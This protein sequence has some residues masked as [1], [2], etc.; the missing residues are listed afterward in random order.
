MNRATVTRWWLIRHAAVL[1]QGGRIMGQTDVPCAHPGEDI[2]RGLLRRLPRDVQWVTTPLRRTAQTAE[3]IAEIGRIAIR[4][5]HVE[6]DF[7]EQSY[8]EWEKLTWSD[9]NGSS[10]DRVRTFWD[11]PATTAPPGGE[12]FAHVIK[13]TGDALASLTRQFAGRDVIAVVHAGTIRAA[14]AVA[15]EMDPRRALAF[16]VDHLSLTRLDHVRS[17]GGPGSWRINSVNV[18]HA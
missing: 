4:D 9:L 11:A 8:G 16:K 17:S 5:H 12:S 13:R 14:L 15:L 3:A 2:A 6:P 7:M 18:T 1:D 10:D